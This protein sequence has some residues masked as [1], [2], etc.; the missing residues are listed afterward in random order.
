MKIEERI[1]RPDYGNVVP[2]SAAD[3]PAGYRATDYAKPAVSVDIAVAARLDGR[4]HMLLIR[5]GRPPYQGFWALPGGFLEMHE[6]LAD[7]AARE[8]REET[9]IDLAEG[10]AAVLHFDQLRA[11]GRPGRDPR[12]RVV[13]VTFLAVVD[14]DSVRPVAGDDASDTAWVPL[15]AALESGALAF[16]HAEALSRVKER[17]GE[18]DTLWA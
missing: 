18:L 11:F 7:A 6:D 14:P 13:T 15:D 4:V 12:D 8:L 3:V 5:R 10:G 9:G 17:L 2:G 16:D 1:E